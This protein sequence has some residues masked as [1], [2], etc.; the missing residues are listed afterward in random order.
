[1]SKF[2]DLIKKQRSKKKKEKFQGTFLEYLEM[3]KDNPDK[4]KL[5]HKRLYETIC[6][7]GVETVDVDSDS[8][9]DICNGDKM[10]A[11]D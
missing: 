11:Y 9:R 2:L 8:Y 6:N 1:M 4:I 7:H 10:R 5:A 3:I